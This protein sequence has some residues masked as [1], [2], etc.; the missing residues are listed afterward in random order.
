MWGVHVFD[1]I[2]YGAACKFMRESLW[3]E[4]NQKWSRKAIL[5]NKCK[6]YLPSIFKSTSI[7]KINQCSWKLHCFI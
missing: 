6:E 7:S 4:E 2:W 3:K 5:E 1:V